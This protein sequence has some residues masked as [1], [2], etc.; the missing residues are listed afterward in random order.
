MAAL[1]KDFQKRNVKIKHVVTP[2]LRVSNIYTANQAN[3]AT[4]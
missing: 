4:F 1:K 3:I 2:S